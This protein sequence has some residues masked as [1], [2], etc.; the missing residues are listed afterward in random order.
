M[1]LLPG[2]VW[3]RPCP[4]A[5]GAPVLRTS[6]PGPGLSAGAEAPPTEGQQT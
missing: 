4:A 3:F 6:P 1:F 5:G 2:G